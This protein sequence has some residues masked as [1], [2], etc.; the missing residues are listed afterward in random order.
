[1]SFSL[2]LSWTLW[3]KRCVAPRPTSSCICGGSWGHNPLVLF[4]TIPPMAAQDQPSR[5]VTT[6]A[7]NTTYNL[8][9]QL[10]NDVLARALRD[11]TRNSGTCAIRLIDCA[12]AMRKHGGLLGEIQLPSETL[13]AI[14]RV[15][16]AKPNPYH[17][18]AILGAPLRCSSCCTSSMIRGLPECCLPLVCL[19][20]INK[21]G[22]GAVFPPALLVVTRSNTCLPYCPPRPHG[23]GMLAL[24]TRDDLPFSPGV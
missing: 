8:Q 5:H 1:M 6:Q 23:R 22:P 17:T 10:L 21:T 9:V 14:D 2:S 18:P 11:S 7:A 19:S 16:Y 13:H 15:M 12:G 20:V 4:R 24:R 3:C